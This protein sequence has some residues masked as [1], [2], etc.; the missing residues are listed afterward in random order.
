MRCSQFE[1]SNGNAVIE[2][3]VDASRQAVGG[4]GR[5]KGVVAVMFACSPSRSS[6]ETA[7]AVRDLREPLLSKRCMLLEKACNSHGFFVGV[8]SSSRSSSPVGSVVA[9]P[10]AQG[11]R[12]ASGRAIG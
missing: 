3:I 9:G 10:E 5:M 7:E 8:W 2:P 1:E 11:G 6:W 12:G 4:D